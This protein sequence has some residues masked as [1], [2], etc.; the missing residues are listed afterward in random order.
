MKSVNL[1]GKGQIVLPVLILISLILGQSDSNVAKYLV[2]I[3]G[4]IEL[5]IIF[6]AMHVDFRRTPIIVLLYFVMIIYLTASL[7][8]NFTMNYLSVFI[9]QS[10][11][12]LSFFINERE[13]DDYAFNRWIRVNNILL[14]I[15]I[16]MDIAYFLRTNHDYFSVPIFGLSFLFVLKRRKKKTILLLLALLMFFVHGR[17]T[18][19]A[20]LVMVFFV[21]LIQKISSKTKVYTSVFWIV[22][23]L[24]VYL[25]RVYLEFYKSHYAITANQFIRRITGKNL[26]SGRELLW[27][28][29]YK[30]IDNNPIFGVGGQY[31]KEFESIYGAST[32]NVFI[33]LRIEGGYILLLI[34]LIF[35]FYIWMQIYRYMDKGYIPICAAYIVGLFVRI[36]FDLTFIANNFGQSILLWIPIILILN[37]CRSNMKNE[38]TQSR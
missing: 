30:L 33:F 16:V 10:V 3:I 32:H 11:L 35:M 24:T 25:P 8:L 21:W 13:Y 22:S 19:L 17:S 36:S 12:F 2:I 20:F 23:I 31:Y 18:S 37:R 4:L 38:L 14:A 1:F 15:L 26:F 9:Q 29:A 7:V 28:N 27:L 6:L 34:F 5:L